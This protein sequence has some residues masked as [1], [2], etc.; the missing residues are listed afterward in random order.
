M[1]SVSEDRQQQLSPGLSLKT[2]CLVASAGALV[3]SGEQTIDGV[4]CVDGDRVLVKDQASDIDNGIYVVSTGSWSRAQDFDGSRDAVDGTIVLVREGSNAFSLWRAVAAT[5]P[6]VI[7]TDAVNFS[8][9]GTAGDAANL[10]FLQAGVGAVQR[11][12]QSKMRDVVC[13]KDFATALDGVTDD[14]AAYQACIDSVKGASE[15][16][17]LAET[18]YVY[19]PKGIALTSAPLNLYSGVVLLGEGQ[20]SRIKA[21]GGFAGAA[22]VLLKGQGANAYC[23]FAGYQHMGFECTGAI[24]CV[25]QSAAA[26]VNCNFIDGWMSCGFGLDLGIYAQGCLIETLFGVGSTDQ[27]LHVQGNFNKIRNVDKEGGT[28]SSADPYILIE[29]HAA[30]R[31]NGNEL[32]GILIEQ[33]TSVNKSLIKL[34]NCESTVLSQVWMEPTLTDGY[35]LRIEGCVNTRIKSIPSGVFATTK[36]KVDTSRF[37]VIDVLDSDGDG[38]WVL[39]TVLEVD[40]TSDVH[41]DRYHNRLGGDQFLLAQ[42]DRN[43]FIKEGYNSTVFTSPIANYSPV[44]RVEWLCGQNFALNGSLEAGR[45]GWTFSTNPT[46]TEEYIASEVGQGLMGHFVWA[47]QGSHNLTQ[48]VTVPS[49]MPVTVTAKVKMT[50]GTGWIGPFTDGVGI[51]NNNGHVRAATGTGWQLITR[52]VIPTSTG[53][54][55]VGFDFINVTAVYVD[56]FSVSVGNTGVPNMGKFGTMEIGGVT[57]ASGAGASPSTGTWKR[58]DVWFRSDASAATS[59]GAVCTAAGSPGTWKAMAAL[60][61]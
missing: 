2:P 3:L 34:L 1:V 11:T 59:P 47:A 27:L 5:Y 31:S 23:Q 25:Q 10:T 22:L 56:E 7:G 54:L 61:A 26:V 36:I 13:V 16:N 24:R 52:T 9:A 4:A 45:Y 39:S 35:G 49:G 6:I 40:A 46:T 19:H 15:T 55:T 28:G 30:G 21:S 57:F 58:G 38:S 51:T 32:E 29:D 20:G 44:Q 60:A 8:L 12:G 14:T 53:A 41:I 50:G 48:N 43:V 18:R 37:T 42:M 33:T 17:P